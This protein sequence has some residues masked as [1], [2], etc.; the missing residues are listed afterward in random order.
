MASNRVATK[1]GQSKDSSIKTNIFKQRSKSTAT[2]N[3]LF[4]DMPKQ[5][6]P[7]SD[8]QASSFAAK[9]QTL[10]VDL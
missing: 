3:L 8:F 1:T 7:T 6:A 4:T 5:E 2:R 9:R 10:P